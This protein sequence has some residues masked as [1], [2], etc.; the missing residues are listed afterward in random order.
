MVVV[1]TGPVPHDTIA[2]RA[3]YR[4]FLAADLQA[5][6]LTRWQPLLAGIRPELH[7]QRVLR[8][9]E[10]LSAQAGPLARLAYL[11]TR[12]RLA[13]LAVQTGISIPPGVF[14]RGLSVAHTGN[15]VVNDQARVGRFCRLH[16]GTNIGVHHGAAPRLGDR[17]YVA[18]GA[19]LFGGITVGDDVLVGAN[20]VVRSDVPPGVTV[21][22][23]PAQVIAHRGS[24]SSMPEWFPPAPTPAPR[25]GTVSR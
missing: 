1:S 2:T 16:S 4:A 19:V 22:G 5:H 7:Y 10:F 18:P 25:D 15:I 8:R 11:L 14:G 24:A 3:D 23:A 12:Y 6:G 17:V 21:G 13:R 20:S 9:A